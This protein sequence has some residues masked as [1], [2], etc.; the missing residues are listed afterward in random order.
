[1]YQ[2]L[3]SGKIVVDPEDSCRALLDPV[4]SCRI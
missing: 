4:G 2:F 1:V 3:G